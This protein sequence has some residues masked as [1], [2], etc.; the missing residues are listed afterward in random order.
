MQ[1]HSLAKG[2]HSA[3]LCRSQLQQ[4]DAFRKQGPVLHCRLSV[5]LSLLRPS[6]SPLAHALTPLA[7]VAVASLLISKLII[8]QG[9]VGILDVLALVPLAPNCGRLLIWPGSTCLD[10][11]ST[12]VCCL[13]L[14]C[15]EIVWLGI[16]VVE[17]PH[18][19]Q[20][21]N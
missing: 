13:L 16:E 18:L 7:A 14:W 12:K 10:V 19:E 20:E 8:I 11:C 21:P 9:E 17:T 15:D 6:L 2:R 5:A 3:V 1:Q 4:L